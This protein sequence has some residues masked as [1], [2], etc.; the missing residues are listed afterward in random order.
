MTDFILDL[1]DFMDEKLDE[2]C[3]STQS[4]VAALA[5]AIGA[6]PIIMN[7]LWQE[8]PTIAAAFTL[9]GF[10]PVDLPDPKLAGLLS[11]KDFEEMIR[12]MKAFLLA[13]RSIL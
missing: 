3:L 1:L 4:R 6:A 12:R 10:A 11:D 13:A 8:R 9:I 2:S 5:E 7:R